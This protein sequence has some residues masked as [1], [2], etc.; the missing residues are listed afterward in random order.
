LGLRYLNVKDGFKNANLVIFL[1][2]HKSFEKLNLEN[3]SKK[4]CKPA[5]IIDTWNVFDQKK[6]R[7]IKGLVYSGLGND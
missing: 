7:Q 1:N 4:M 2:N 3:L 5:I 6:M